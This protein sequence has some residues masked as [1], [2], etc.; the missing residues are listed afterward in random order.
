MRIM[1]SAA[2]SRAGYQMYV[3]FIIF[4]VDRYMKKANVARRWEGVQFVGWHNFFFLSSASLFHEMCENA[5]VF[6]LMDG[7]VKFFL[8]SDNIVG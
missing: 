7:I 8:T 4:F 3:S 5:Q 6:D 2:K 1:Y